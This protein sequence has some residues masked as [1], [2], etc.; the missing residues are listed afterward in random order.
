M[1]AE[2]AMSKVLIITGPAG[3]GKTEVSHFVKVE[4]NK[5]IPKNKIYFLSGDMF[6]HISFP[7]VASS[8]QLVLKYQCLLATLERLIQKPSIIIIDDVFRRSI[9]WKILEEF[10]KMKNVPL[11]TVFLKADIDFLIERNAK[12]KGYQRAPDEHIIK[13]FNQVNELDWSH[14]KLIDA[15]ISVKK[16]ALNIVKAFVSEAF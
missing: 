7:W 15:S 13:I 4:L 8:D 5:L 2:K 3:V 10:I 16:V 12:R 9:D 6:S 14:A 11:Q 1:V